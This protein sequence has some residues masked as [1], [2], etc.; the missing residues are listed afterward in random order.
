[1]PRC[2]GHTRVH[3]VMYSSTHGEYEL[4]IITN[5]S[6]EGTFVIIP[7]LIYDTSSYYSSVVWIDPIRLGPCRKDI[8]LYNLRSSPRPSETLFACHKQRRWDRDNGLWFGSLAAW[9]CPLHLVSGV[10]RRPGAADTDRLCTL[11][12]PTPTALPRR[13]RYGPCGGVLYI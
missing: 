7:S 5:T 10:T 12:P 1:M 9:Q 11:R 13:T 3:G 2:A 4:V 6:R 8:Q